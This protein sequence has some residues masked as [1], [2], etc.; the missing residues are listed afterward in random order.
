MR[1]REDDDEYSYYAPRSR[2][3]PSM[4]SMLG[5]ASLLLVLAAAALEMGLLVVAGVM[6]ARELEGFDDNEPAAVI[7][8]LVLMGGLAVDVAGIMLG[9]A[10]LCLARA[11]NPFAW[12]AVG[13]GSTVLV[14]VLCVVAVGIALG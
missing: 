14:G 7:V 5:L 1:Y 6:S 10:C 4:H 3:A 8:G 2:A 13:V 11:N 12:L 9:V